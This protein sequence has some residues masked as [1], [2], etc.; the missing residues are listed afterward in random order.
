MLHVF[1]ETT[2]GRHHTQPKP[3]GV[4]RFFSL[5]FQVSFI[6]HPLAIINDCSLFP[7]VIHSK[8]SYKL[9]SVWSSILFQRPDIKLQVHHP[10][11]CPSTGYPGA[12]HSGNHLWTEYPTGYTLPLKTSYIP[13]HRPRTIALCRFCATGILFTQSSRLRSHGGLTTHSLPDG[14]RHCLPSLL[15]WFSLSPFTDMSRCNA[16]GLGQTSCNCPYVHSPQLIICP[17]SFGQESMYCNC[18]PCSGPYPAWVSRLGQSTS[19]SFGTY[20]SNW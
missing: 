18:E 5:S 4:V 17:W 1:L 20:I 13:N 6:A 19:C 3:V 7:I 8:V 9:A 2:R 16:T 11:A 12:S 14:I 15:S 10:L